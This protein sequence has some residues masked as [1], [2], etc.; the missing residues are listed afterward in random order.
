MTRPST[1]PRRDAPLPAAFTA[2]IPS[3]LGNLYATSDGQAITALFTPGHRRHPGCDA[4]PGASAPVL[5]E[6]RR[7]LDEYFGG[8]RRHFDLPLAAL[9]TPFQLQVWAE[10][11]RIPYGGTASYGQVAAR[12]GVPAAVRAV[13]AANGRNPISVVVPCHRVVGADGSLTGYAGGVAAKRW[14][15]EHEQADPARQE[16]AP[17]GTTTPDRAAP[18]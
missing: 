5:S 15:L 18:R 8:R 14:L 12:V 1:A 3:P 7:Q 9:G 6:L 17:D 13:G 11:G 4:A 10:L 2:L 16:T